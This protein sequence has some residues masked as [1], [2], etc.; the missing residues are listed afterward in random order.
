LDDSSRASAARI[1]PE[2]M[3]K[4]ALKPSTQWNKPVGE[5]R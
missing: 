5:E 2:K 1:E 4:I 3:R